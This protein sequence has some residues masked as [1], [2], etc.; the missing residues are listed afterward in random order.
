MNAD[1]QNNNKIPFI[2]WK[3]WMERVQTYTWQIIR[4]VIE[5]RLLKLKDHF[6]DYNQQKIVLTT[7]IL[8]KRLGMTIPLP[9]WKITTSSFTLFLADIK[10]K[11]R[12]FSVHGRLLMKTFIWFSIFRFL[13]FLAHCQKSCLRLEMVDYWTSKWTSWWWGGALMMKRDPERGIQV[14][15]FLLSAYNR[16]KRVTKPAILTS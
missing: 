7:S 6:R 9:W 11:F 4:S 13:M 2:F 12:T 1:E 3:L 8:R 5:L 16:C 15:S 14:V 10:L